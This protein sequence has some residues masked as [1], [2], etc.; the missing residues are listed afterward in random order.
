MA[1]SLREEYVWAR[2]DMK[3]KRKMHLNLKEDLTAIPKYLKLLPITCQQT[4]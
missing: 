2:G 1:L 4:T 3:W